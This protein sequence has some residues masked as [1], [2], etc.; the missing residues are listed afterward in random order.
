M[1]DIFASNGQYLSFTELLSG[2]LHEIGWF[3]IQFIILSGILTLVKQFRTKRLATAVAL[4][5]PIIQIIYVWSVSIRSEFFIAVSFAFLLTM[6]LLILHLFPL[7]IE[8]YLFFFSVFL[9]PTR[10]FNSTSALLGHLWLFWVIFCVC[11]AT[12]KYGLHKLHGNQFGCYFLYVML[13]ISA[14]TFFLAVLFL[15]PYSNNLTGDYAIGLICIIALMLISFIGGTIFV[16]IKFYQQILKLTQFGQKYPSIERYFFSFSFL[17]LTICTLIFLPFTIMASQNSLVLLLF[18]GLCLVLLWLQLPFIMLLFHVAFYKDCATF[19]QWEKEGLVAY[20]QNLAGSLI[21]IQDIRHDIKNIF[22]T[23]GNFVDH[24]DNQEMKDFFWGKIYPYSE[25][26]IHQSEL[27]CS[28]YQ[29]PIE[30]LRAFFYLK[31]SQAI[32]QKIQVSLKIHII[33]E[34][35]QTSMDIIDLT[36]ILGILLDNAIDEAFKVPNGIIEVRISGNIDGCSYTIKN[37]ITEQT[38]NSGIHIGKTTK[39]VGHGKGLLIVQQLLEQYNN[40]IMNS[41]IQNQMFIQSLNIIRNSSN[42]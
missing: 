14:Y 16:R 7:H 13:S 30:P 18:P 25:D 6:Q 21:T 19:S 12:V 26:T 35:F 24:S 5:M 8:D 32:H 9:F 37:S 42:S 2:S 38:K 39:G 28:I 33:P 3:S 17:I 1:V 4:L 11:Y 34:K 41:C 36:R 23:M 31:L 29:L 27:L 10:L 22:F 20:Y 40:A 15:Y